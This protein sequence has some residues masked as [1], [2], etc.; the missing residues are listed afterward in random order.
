M[1]NSHATTNHVKVG[2]QLTGEDGNVIAHMEL[3]KR[4]VADLLECG[5]V[6]VVGSDF[7]CRTESGSPPKQV[8]YVTL[9]LT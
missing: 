2:L 9:Y 4:I 6:T 1:P 8:R 7:S 3:S 5:R